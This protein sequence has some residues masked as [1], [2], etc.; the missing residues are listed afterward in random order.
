MNFARRRLSATAIE[1]RLSR[2]DLAMDQLHVQRSRQG[3]PMMT[4]SEAR[5]VI[6]LC[7]SD[8][9]LPSLLQ[10]FGANKVSRTDMLRL[11]GEEWQRCG[12]IG[13]YAN[14]LDDILPDCHAA[15]MM[16]G[17]ERQTLA[18]LPSHLTLYRGAD[19][20]V[21]ENGFSWTLH[22]A[23]AQAF[24]FFHRYRAADPV[25]LTATAP[26]A[27]IV[28]LKIDREERDVIIRPAWLHIRMVQSI[29]RHSEAI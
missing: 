21:N 16:T 24:P 25:L 29:Q 13:Q 3:V 6:G 19:R 5:R 2:L 23:S 22:R 18:G 26:R 7:D 4:L 15:E 27:K 11:L 20:G 1:K 28:A 10:L 17:L 12:T 14:E 8:T 9:R